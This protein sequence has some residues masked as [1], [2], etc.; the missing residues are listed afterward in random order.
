MATQRKAEIT[1]VPPL[2]LIVGDGPLDL[3]W[4]YSLADDRT[5]Q[6]ETGC[7][8]YAAILRLERLPTPDLVFLDAEMPGMD[9]LETL[10]QLRLRQP[11][12]R[13]VMLTSAH[14]PQEV[15]RAVHLGAED[16]LLKPCTKE[17]IG[18][19]LQWG[20][21]QTAGGEGRLPE[22]VEVLADGSTFVA[23]SPAMRKLRALV[24]EVAATDIPVLCTGES[25][26]GKE[27]IARL[28]HL[29]SRRNHHPFLKVNCAALPGE[30][31]ESELFGYEQGAFTGAV[32][33][34]P[35]KFELCNK[36]TI[37]LD[38]LAEMPPQLQAKLLHV[39]QDGEFTRLG[40]RARI[41]TDVR[42]VAATNVDIFAAL[43]SNRLREDLY[44]RLSAILLEVPPLRERREE[45]P[46]LL[47][48]F[49]VKYGGKAGLPSRRPS[50]AMMDFAVL[51]D[52]P[53]NVR[54]MENFAKRYLA[55]GE[56]ALADGNGSYAWQ[57]TIH[58]V[59]P[60]GEEDR[61]RFPNLKA[62][63]NGV[64][65]DAESTIIRRT[66]EQTNWNRKEAARILQVSYKTLLGKLRDYA[67]DEPQ[68][69]NTIASLAAQ[70]A[71]Q[72]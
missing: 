9:S 5:C 52:W 72:G 23:S 57:R 20:V 68:A 22:L 16:C 70:N 4:V 24:G 41:K 33:P 6:V 53:G 36:G 11:S 62:H 50:A 29:L 37:L 39:L 28:L 26:T 10:R 60:T 58:A 47:R 7:S 46:A 15:V 8:G 64:K 14:D 71:D 21:Q 18:K 49:L 12:L 66:L 31:L 59:S 34:K 54:E 30:L 43:A 1:P 44:Y 13:V 3:S 38:E 63:I 32:R 67:L 19:L 65:Q 56:R 27:V 61:N 48:H 45:I 51:Y 42:V 40:G 25:G 55:L 35:G 17:S 2:I 69:G